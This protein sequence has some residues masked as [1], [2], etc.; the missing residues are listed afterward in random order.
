MLPNL[1]RLREER[2]ISQ[3]KLADAV[4]VSQPSIFKYENMNIEPDI[5]VLSQ[6]ADYF[7][8]SVDYII[9]RTEERRPIER[10]EAYDLNA[11]EARLISAYR[12]MSDEE[13]SCL[14]HVARTI[15]HI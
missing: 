13:R 9:G 5:A 15:V 6:L 14:E 2:R 1:K 11:D 12:S 8:T 10:T 4:G 3:Q 7:D